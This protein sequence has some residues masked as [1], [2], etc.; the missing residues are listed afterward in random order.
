ML[1]R[2]API[3]GHLSF[4]LQG[5]F[6]HKIP[7][8]SITVTPDLFLEPLIRDAIESRKVD[9][10]NYL[11]ASNKQNSLLDLVGRDN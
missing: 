4:F 6:E 2:W 7:R 10:E 11:L 3:C 8:K 5:Q 1:L 9:I